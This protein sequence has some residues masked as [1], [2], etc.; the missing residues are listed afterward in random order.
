MNENSRTLLV[1]III[2]ALATV[3][4]RFK[5]S[6]SYRTVLS[7]E[8]TK[9]EI[10]EHIRYLS[11][12]DRAGR[13][14]GSRESKDVIS[15]LIS[16]LKSYGIKPGVG[17]DS[18]V[19]PFDFTDNIE[20]G[21]KNTLIIDTDTL[22]VESDFIPLWFSGNDS[23]TTSAIFAGYGFN[24]NTDEIKWNDYEDLNVS[25]KWV[26]V[27]RN[28]PDRDIQNSL[29]RPHA[30]LH[31]KMLVARDNGAAGIIYI[32]QTEDDDLFP[33]RYIA[34]Y[35]NGG[36]PAIH[37]SN[38]TADKLLKQ[39]GWSRKK[40]QDTM[41]KSLKP[42]VFEMPNI[43]KANITLKPVDIRAGNV[44]GL[45]KSGNRR[46]RDE[47][48]VLGA[49]FDHIGI[50]G[51]GSGSRKPNATEIHYGADDNAS[52][53]A[54]I[55]ELAQKLM[56]HKSRL[57]R[58]V[59]LVGFDAEEKGLL[60]AKH[61]VENPPVSLDKI[62]AMINLD[63]IGRVKDSTF[64]IGGVGT[65]SIFQP[66]LD[67]L[68]SNSEYNTNLT[69]PGFGPSDHAAF[70]A[71]DIPVLFFFSGVHSEYHTPDDTWKLINLDGEKHILET[72]HDVVFHL[73]SMTE[74]PDFKEA[75]PREGQMTRNASFRVTFGIMPAYGSIEEGLEVDGISNTD[76][77]AAKAGI[78]KGD[79][80]KM[81]NGK[82]IKDIYEFMDRLKE[83]ETGMT[84]PVIIERDGKKKELSVSF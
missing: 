81:I 24:I 7:T 66:L 22:L 19:Q 6:G 23:I 4:V 38:K 80:I 37:L 43:V 15:Y 40:I 54:G 62:V 75:G 60:G 65:S 26:F 10:M 61:F 74:K 17:G 64:T 47:Y 83:L 34:G 33:L 8:I 20:L 72:V 25:G 55:L 79:I 73:A 44:V 50:G 1:F 53:T 16:N 39:I 12:K 82:E 58:S 78:K 59:L 32:S 76:G 42:V 18:Y 9:D 3:L 57:K 67:S 14:P 77:P 30:S 28:S 27:M 48:I 31:K 36:I 2:I 52:G 56:S 45:I 63:M 13:Y 70:Y 21:E 71:K 69:L 49:H 5:N 51:P 11:H 46:Y 68:T 35:K 84:I 41:N 29:Y